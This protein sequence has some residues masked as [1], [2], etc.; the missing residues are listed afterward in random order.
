MIG[1]RTQSFSPCSR[2]KA[3]IPAPVIVLPSCRADAGP[4]GC[5]ILGAMT[6]DR[7]TSFRLHPAELNALRKAAARNGIVINEGD[8]RSAEDY[9]EAVFMGLDDETVANLTSFLETGS[10]PGRDEAIAQR[11]AE[12]RA[13]ADEPSGDPVTD[14]LAAR[15]AARRAP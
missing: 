2:A 1:H 3:I 5:A 15:R 12:E 8:I 4:Y 14:E 9:R 6:T 11:A 10:Y 7:N 13:A